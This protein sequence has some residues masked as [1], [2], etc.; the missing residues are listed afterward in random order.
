MMA[1]ITYLSEESMR[2]KFGRRLQDSAIPR[3]GFDVDFQVE[4]YLQH[5][6]ASFLRRFDANSYL[7]LTRVMDYFDPFA[8]P[9]ATARALR[10]VTSRFLVISFDSDWRFD[11]G[12]SREIVRVL[13][14]H[15]V[16][17]TFREVSSPHGHDSFLL[18]VPE[19]HR[20]VAAFLGRVADD[21][22]VA[23]T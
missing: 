14:G 22:G 21:A 2:R 9:A 1:H 16:P 18:E 19:Y 13:A 5:Q 3:F 6:G 7:Y 4:S 8:D 20:T 15:G 12:H 10:E 23:R 17:V 11:T